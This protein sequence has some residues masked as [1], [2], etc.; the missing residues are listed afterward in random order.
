MPDSA[1]WVTMLR[2]L[3]ASEWPSALDEHSGLPGPRANLTLLETVISLADDDV[4]IALE[5]DGREYPM[6]CAAAA[7]AST[8]DEPAHEAK[9]HALALDARWR[10]REGVAIGLQ[11]LGDRQL[12]AMTSIVRRWAIDDDPL[13]QR[14][15][16]AAICEPRL[17]RHPDSAAVALEVC[18][19]TTAALAALPDA[20]RAASDARVL[21]QALGYCWSV[22][23]AADPQQGLPVFLGLDVSRPDVAWIVRENRKK[24]R[25][26]RLVV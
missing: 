1:T 6:M 22:A 10:V 13:V 24:Q 18:A 17:L 4:V 23:V 11:H 7:L 5:D 26:A 15:A 16:V 2:G 20:R 12:V 9:A 3:D 8:S 19:T 25:L 14:A 21:R